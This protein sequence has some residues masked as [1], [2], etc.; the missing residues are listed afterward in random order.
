MTRT[1][2]LM[3]RQGSP[4]AAPS[5]PTRV[6]P[7]TFSHERRRPSRGGWGAPELGLGLAEPGESTCLGQWTQ[8]STPWEALRVLVSGD[9]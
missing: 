4:P 2:G 9:R 6:L 1:A 8:E 5:A 3:G 7:A